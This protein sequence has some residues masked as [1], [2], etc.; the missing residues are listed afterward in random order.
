MLQ[1]KR[2]TSALVA[3]IT[4]ALT[5]FSTHLPPGASPVNAFEC[6]GKTIRGEIQLIPPGMAFQNADLIVSVENVSVQD[7]KVRRL[8]YQKFTDISYNG[9][10]ETV[11]KFTLEGLFPEPNYRYQVRVLVDLDHD[12]RISVGD[13]RSTR[14]TPVFT[15]K[16]ADPLIVRAEIK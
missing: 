16:D 4:L 3:T 13:Y 2:W 5:L 10:P 11:L 8:A 15:G 9:G 1:P 7:V 12:E 14:P 6:R